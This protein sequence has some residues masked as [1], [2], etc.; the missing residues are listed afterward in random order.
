M[1]ESTYCSPPHP[2]ACA[3]LNA[4]ALCGSMLVCL[5]AKN[6]VE[7]NGG[8]AT[9]GLRG[10]PILRMTK[11]CGCQGALPPPRPQHQRLQRTRPGGSA[12]RRTRR[13]GRGFRNQPRHLRPLPPG[14]G[15]RPAP[16]APRPAP[17]APRP[18]PRA[19]PA[20]TART[21]RAAGA[22]MRPGESRGVKSTRAARAAQIVWRKQV[23]DTFSIDGCAATATPPSGS[24][25]ARSAQHARVRGARPPADRAAVAAGPS[26]GTCWRARGAFR[27][28]SCRSAAR[29]S[30]AAPRS[31]AS[32]RSCPWPRGDRARRVRGGGR[33]VSDLYGVTDAACPLSTRR[34]GGGGAKGRSV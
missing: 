15:A 8:Q 3:V 2:P 26:W 18:A 9:C 14:R 29:S 6:N 28:R 7:L 1:H 25:G 10:G 4:T 24:N 16:R 30:G 12:D 22:S 19:P 32:P 27:A 5:P 17:R 11:D 23:R 13:V 21:P 31:C 33:G 20:G 34:G